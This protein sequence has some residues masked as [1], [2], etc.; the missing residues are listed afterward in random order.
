MTRKNK[1]IFGR[2]IGSVVILTAGIGAFLGYLY[3]GRDNGNEMKSYVAVAP[4]V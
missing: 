1:I 4:I 2:G 3:Y